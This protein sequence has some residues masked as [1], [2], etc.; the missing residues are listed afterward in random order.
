M[1]FRLVPERHR[2][3]IIF[4]RQI[5]RRDSS[6][7]PTEGLD[8]HPEVL[9]EADRVVNVPTVEPEALSGVVDPSGGRTCA[10][11]E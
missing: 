7:I 8:R 10:S 2:R 1:R 6:C 4:E 5:S 3:N 11:P 9:F